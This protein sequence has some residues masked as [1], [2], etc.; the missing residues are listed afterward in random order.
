MK[1]DFILFKK[2]DLVWNKILYNLKMYK[3]IKWNISI[4]INVYNRLAINE[5]EDYQ[6]FNSELHFIIELQAR[7]LSSIIESSSIF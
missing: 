2:N 5:N 4:K 1:S 3:N 6:R 7:V